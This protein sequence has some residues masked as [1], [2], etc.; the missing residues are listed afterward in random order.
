M[1]GLTL[2]ALLVTGEPDGAPDVAGAL[3]AARDPR[4]VTTVVPSFDDA[5]DSL[6]HGGPDVV[7]VDLALEQAEKGVARI[8]GVLGD[9]PM[10]ALTPPEPEGRGM[11]LLRAGVDDFC[12]RHDAAEVVVRTV[13]V[14]V[15][16]AA[17][18]AGDSRELVARTREHDSAELER[19]APRPTTDLTGATF[20]E[21]LL[22]V[23]LP[24]E[25]RR[26][27]AEYGKAL[28]DSLEEL[29]MRV[30]RGV[31]G[32]LRRLAD[33]LGSLRAGPRDVVEV[34]TAAVEQ[35]SRTAPA[36]RARAYLEEGRLM[37][38]QLMGDLVSYYRRHAQVRLET[39]PHPA[40]DSTR[41][42]TEDRR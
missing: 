17:R 22:S 35:R 26:L 1:K 3:A 5:L 34:H 30:D 11:A 14:A 41:K 23:R 40:S 32:R 25:F 21:G 27:S 19:L 42:A 2:R 6:A 33:D 37:V 7:L 31:A 4:V 12:G 8:R 39:D 20:G 36:A 38:L 9:T 15:E 10:V 28:E 13:A 24:A 29:V 16:R 18:H